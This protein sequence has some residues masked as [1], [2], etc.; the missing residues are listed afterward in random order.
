MKCTGLYVITDSTMAGMS[1]SSIVKESI[2]GGARIIQVRDKEMADGQLLQEM[3]QSIKELSDHHM[4]IVND[5]VDVGFLAG[6][7]GIHLGQD[8]LPVSEVRC[9]LGNEAIIGISTHNIK[10]FEQALG[11]DVDYI[12][13]GPIYDTATKIS[14]NKP[15]GLEYVT[16]LRAMTDKPLVAIGGI[17]LER[18]SKLWKE[19]IDAVAVV[20]D[21]MKSV[22]ISGKIAEYIQLFTD[23]CSLTTL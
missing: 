18:A 14:S 23:H 1:H 17:T 5:R 21:I 9:L 7:K 20:S 2:K 10:Q 4:L 12:A 8:D 19:G 3:R 16:T 22:D 11:E 13:I 6:A 15:L